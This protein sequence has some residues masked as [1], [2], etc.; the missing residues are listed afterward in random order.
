M[1]TLMAMLKS[2]FYSARPKWRPVVVTCTV[3]RLE[4]CAAVQAVDVA[5]IIQEH[6]HLDRES[7][8]FYTDCKVV[9]GYIC[10]EIRRF[11][12]YV[13]NRVSRIRESSEP[14]LWN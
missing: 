9:L 2:A 14:A 4:L 12:M 6:L 1:L 3:P 13:A 10:N 8:F 5:S 11:Y 7:M